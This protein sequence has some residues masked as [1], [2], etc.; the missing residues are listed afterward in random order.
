M[1]KLIERTPETF[2]EKQ[3]IDANVLHEVTD[4]DVSEPLT[5]IGS[6][7]ASDARARRRRLKPATSS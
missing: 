3:D 5:R 1:N 4:L 6:L 7:P 2:R